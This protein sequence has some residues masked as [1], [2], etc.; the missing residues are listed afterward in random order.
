MLTVSSRTA[1]NV[2]HRKADITTEVAHSIKPPD[3]L[4][5]YLNAL[6]GRVTHGVSPYSIALA[7]TDW[8]LHLAGSPGKWMQLVEKAI[9]KDQRWLRYAFSGLMGRPVEPC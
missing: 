3:E 2:S 4:D 1:P 7:Y 5:R 6:M 8:M 9:D